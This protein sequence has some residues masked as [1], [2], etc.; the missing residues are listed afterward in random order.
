[1]VIDSEVIRIWIMQKKLSA[2]NRSLCGN[3]IFCLIL[4]FHTNKI[5]IQTRVSNSI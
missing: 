1:M 2:M 5:Q 4:E 3:I